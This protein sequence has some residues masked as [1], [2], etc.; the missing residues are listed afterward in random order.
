M[1][2]KWFKGLPNGSLSTRLAEWTDWDVAMWH[3]AVLIGLWDDCGN[4]PGQGHKEDGPTDNWNGHKGTIWSSN[5]TSR[6]LGD[7]L[8]VLVRAGILECNE[9]RQYRW[10]ALPN[11]SAKASP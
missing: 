2:M 11:S 4:P 5:A 6:T 8:A 9:E 3:V 1:I 7:V 10:R